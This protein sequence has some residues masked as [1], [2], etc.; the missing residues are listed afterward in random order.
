MH[1]VIRLNISWIFSRNKI[2]LNISFKCVEIAHDTDKEI[3]SRYTRKHYDKGMLVGYD[4]DYKYNK[5]NNHFVIC[6][7]KCK[8]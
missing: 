1:C 5:D 7:L 6:F 8:D 2:C 3:I 4:L